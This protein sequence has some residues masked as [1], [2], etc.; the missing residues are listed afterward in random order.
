MKA[1]ALEWPKM[2]EEA[3]HGI[4]GEFTGLVDPHSEADP[5]ALLLQFLSAPDVKKGT[6]KGDCPFFPF[7]MME[8]GKK[9]LINEEV[10]FSDYDSVPFPLDFL[11]KYEYNLKGLYL[12]LIIKKFRE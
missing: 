3:F 1:F 7:F 8:G 6:E 9:A 10:I 12:L 5:V 4:T 2:R 11:K